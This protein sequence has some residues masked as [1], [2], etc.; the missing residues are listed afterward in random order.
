MKQDI[1]GVDI[2][3]VILDWAIAKGT[4]VAFSGDNYLQTPALPDVFESLALLNTGRFKDNVFLVSK[5]DHF[6]PG[7]ILEWLEHHDFY[8][9][10]GIPKEHLNFCTE[11]A[12]KAA[13]CER[14][15][16]QYFIDDRLEVLSHLVGIVPTLYLFRPSNEEVE[17][18]KEHLPQVTRVEEWNELVQLLG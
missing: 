11:R 5:H 2:G 10:T 7:R 3:G 13:I 17:N 18:F 4:D 9:R 14:L 15:G 6:G 16:I 1:L 12:E 8:T